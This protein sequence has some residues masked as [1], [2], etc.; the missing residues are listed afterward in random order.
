VELASE[1]WHSGYIAPS[2]QKCKHRGHECIACT[3]TVFTVGRLPVASVRN[4]QSDWMY[5]GKGRWEGEPKANY[6]NCFWLSISPLQNYL[7]THDL[8]DF[9]YRIW[10]ILLLTFRLHSVCVNFMITWFLACSEAQRW[11]WRYIH[12]MHL[13]NVGIIL[14]LS[15]C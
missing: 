14:I 15:T 7:W 8:K 6:I 12:T 11:P 9:K 2:K 4:M 13:F 5:L 1:D 3:Y 10:Y